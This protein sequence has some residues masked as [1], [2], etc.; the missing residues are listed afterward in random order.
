MN[1]GELRLHQR[2]RRQERLGQELGLGQRQSLKV[3]LGRSRDTGPHKVEQL[4][5]DDS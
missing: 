2:H 5:R 4:H 1:L 3:P